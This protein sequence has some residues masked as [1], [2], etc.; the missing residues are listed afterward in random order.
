MAETIEHS[1]ELGTSLIVE[2][3]TGTGKTFGYLVPIFLSQKKTIISTGTKNLQD[4]LFFNDIPIIKKIF[5]LPRKVVLLKGRAN[6]LCKHRVERSLHDGYFLS[7]QQ[8]SQLN[9]INE[10]SRATQTGDIVEMT[11]VPE[12]SSIWPQVTSTVDNCLNQDCSFY[13]ECFV[14]KARQEAMAADILV[15]NHHLFFANMAL[16]DRGFGELLP[17][18]EVVIF[19]EAHQIPDI[20]SQFFSTTLT[21]R[22]LIELARDSETEAGKEAKDMKQIHDQSLSLQKAVQN[23]RNSLGIELRRALWPET[24]PPELERSIQDV[25]S[26]LQLLESILRDAAIRGKGLENC[27]RRCVHLLEVF[28]LLSEK[29]TMDTVHWF[30]TYSQSFSLQIT[31]IVIAKPFQNYIKNLKR[32]W[33]Y[34]SATLTVKNSFHL[35]SEALGL[36]HVRQLQLK[37]PFDY[38]RQSLLYVPR[39]LPDPRASHYLA[40]MLETVIPVL[41]IT[42]GKAFIL[43]TSYK[44]LG[45]AAEQLKNR[46]PYPL[47]LQGAAPK[48][49]LINDFKRLGNAVLLGTSSFWYGVDV[50]GEALSCVI[51][52]KLPFASPEDPILKARIERVRKQGMDPFQTYQ[53]P[54]AVLLLKQGAGRLI[55]DIQDRGILMICDPRLVSSNYGQTFLQSLPEMPRTRELDKVREFFN[56]ENTCS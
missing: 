20:A 11:T 25:K 31:P 55:R 4:Q 38:A 18:A 41:E 29:S 2:A 6:Y 26:N 34:T 27:W 15:V 14:V 44:A 56:Y 49:Q 19:D 8:L 37:S 45:L 16:Q 10:W 40:I 12:D 48:Q 5:P 33:I 13:K 23:M 1:L 28:N 22:Q 53:L 9:L 42:Q 24:P 30:E 54:N 50:R 36:N 3:G 35:F 17:G 47:L 7:R 43:F 32:S 52:D 39:S 46:I 51:I 21:G